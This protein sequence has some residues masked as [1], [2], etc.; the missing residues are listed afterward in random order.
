MSAS[1]IVVF[2]VGSD[3]S[4]DQFDGYRAARGIMLRW[5][6]PDLDFPPFGFDV[7]RAT[8]PD[9]PPL[10]FDD[11][12][13]A[14][15][16]GALNW[17]YGGIVTLSCASGLTFQQAGNPGWNALVITPNAPVRVK[18]NGTAWRI[19][20]NAAPIGDGIEVVALVD[21]VETLR[22]KLDQPNASLLW[23][24]RHVSEIV[25]RGEGSVSFIGFHLLDDT[26]FWTHIAHRCLP[27]HDAAYAC[28]PRSAATEEDEAAMR[29]P[30]AVAAD[31][32]KRFGDPFKAMLPTL[33]RLAR[34][35]APAAIPPDT[36]DSRHPTLT[37][38]SGS[39]EQ[40]LIRIALLDPH[41]AR[42]LGLA[43]DDPLVLNGQE[44]A[45]KVTGIWRGT[46]RDVDGTG[47]KLVDFLKLLGKAGARYKD[48]ARSSTVSLEFPHGAIDF[49]LQADGTSALEWVAED[50]N[51]HR[52]QGVLDRKQRTIALTR[53]AT[54]R[55]VWQSGRDPIFT[56]ASWYEADRRVGILPSVYAID[57]GAPGGPQ[58][59]EATVQ[60]PDSPSGIASAALDWPLPVGSDGATLEGDAVAYQVGR[61]FLGTP[62]LASAPATGPAT[63]AD[64]A[65]P[66]S[67][68]YLSQQSIA[69]QPPRKLNVDYN[70]GK[71]L[72]PGWWGW[73]VRGVDLFGRVSAASSW[74]VGKVED[75]AKPPAPVLVQA[76]WVQRSLPPMTVAVMGRS[77]E[78]QR[79]LTETNDED[80]QPDAA[81]VAAWAMPPEQAE[82][83]DDVDGFRLFM[84]KAVP[85]PGAAL[86]A[87]LEYEPWPAQITQHSPL[88][89][90]Q[91]GPLQIVGRGTIVSVTPDPQL[92]VTLSAGE[93]VPQAPQSPTPPAIPPL[94]RTAFRTDLTLDGASGVFV[95]GT[96]TIGGR[97]LTVVTNGDGPELVVVV[98]HPTNAPPPVAGAATLQA[99]AGM[100]VSFETD[101]PDIAGVPHL[102]ARSG[103]FLDEKATPARFPVLRKNGDEFLCVN[104]Q[105]PQPP[106]PLPPVPIVPPISGHEITW[107]P[108]WFASLSDTGFGP[109]AGATKPVVNAQVA[110]Q[111]V[112]LVQTLAL[113]SA[114]SA[115]LTVTAVDVAP[116][117]TPAIDPIPFDP[118]GTCAELASRADWYGDSRFT[119]SWTPQG[120]C[121]FTVYRALAD[122]VFRLDREHVGRPAARSPKEERWPPGVWADAA[123][124]A[125]IEQE[126]AALD[127]AL[128]TAAAAAA[129]AAVGSDTADAAAA[130]AA[131][132]YDALCNDT[133]MFLGLQPHTWAAFTPLFGRP[134]ETNSYTDTLNGRTRAHWFYA[135]TARSQAGME[136]RPSKISPPICCPDVVPPA[137]PL[138]H[139][140][141]AAEG[142]VKL[143][144][145]AC[146]DA[147][148]KLYE[149]YA[150]READAVKRLDALIPVPSYAGCGAL[151][152]V[153]LH[154]GGGGAS[155]LIGDLLTISGGT[156]IS[157][158]VTVSE[159]SAGG[160]ITGVGVSTRGTYTVNPTV[161]G[162]S[163][164]GGTGIGANLDLTIATVPMAN[165]IATGMPVAPEPN[166]IPTPHVSG[167][168]LE[169]FVPRARNEMGEWCFWIVATDIAGNR[170]EP[171]RTMRARALQPP[172]LPPVWVS[173]TRNAGLIDLEWTYPT[174]ANGY[175]ED[176][177]W[178]CQVERR[179]AG[180][181]LWVAITVWLPRGV[182]STTEHSPD[183]NGAWDYR[184]RVRDH[185]G[186]T[187]PTLPVFALA[188]AP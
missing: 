62:A 84:R 51:G 21:G 37:P 92:A 98:E 83:R 66:F 115:T 47:L 24:A 44:Y 186:M 147:D 67:P 174:G 165:A 5:F 3:A 18:F 145:L 22:K 38:S 173:A 183:P 134:V 23:R 132:A 109:V 58:T 64:V 42:I 163:P 99:K 86:G 178:A 105:L 30:A 162:N 107:H 111:A 53:V 179:A 144:W 69:D 128:A 85:K 130:A 95:G 187:A 89:I 129:A 77:V 39:G 149:I 40:A 167:K 157:A 103:L 166:Y 48:N 114:H 126:L 80:P 131:A 68:L 137:P 164:T 122:E 94:A 154:T 172:P 45:Y 79:W 140:A 54:L 27:V 46:R 25:L 108:V 181:A 153:T 97:A 93:R 75:V 33:H 31:W 127:A 28:A 60:L 76:E 2:G 146:P 112:R 74:D 61:R 50:D 29:L 123:R 180:G 135:V 116:P 78:A 169:R 136:S 106:L 11:V 142:A 170:S 176:P 177:R 110:V 120:D 34:R 49:S 138:A 7:H 168:T 182:Y 81:L 71:G 156:G 171:S 121:T 161:T 150:A 141:L 70:D 88:Q 184:V 188:A 113:P 133:Q 73:W 59:I 90:G 4:I 14:A 118:E 87:P 119:F 175:S 8:I 96:L 41:V 20:V 151:T 26:R 158:T 101:V 57:P 125:R 148:T 10:P 143:K 9:I 32:K 17:A 160:V 104:P 159:V 1:A 72:G 65:R 91:F 55:L 100:L 16:S 102:M 36:L 6:L 185:L 82:V 152:A 52:F 124:K 19:Q 13:T 56:R 15:A 43:Y 63:A 139:S 155:Y 35:D 117:P 12:N